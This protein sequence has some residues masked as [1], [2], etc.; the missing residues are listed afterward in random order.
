MFILD[1]GWNDAPL[2]D[3]QHTADLTD[4]YVYDP[5]SQADADATASKDTDFLHEIIHG[6]EAAADATSTVTLELDAEDW[7]VF[8]MGAPGTGTAVFDSSTPAPEPEPEEPNPGK[9][10]VEQDIENIGT[11]RYSTLE[12]VVRNVNL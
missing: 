5:S 11:A 7:F 2:I 6:D 3:T 4:I 1:E 8:A 10:L 9:A 12:S